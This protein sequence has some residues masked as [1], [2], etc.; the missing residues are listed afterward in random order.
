MTT[1][2]PYVGATWLPSTIVAGELSV[3]DASTTQTLQTVSTYYQITQWTTVQ[4]AYNAQPSVANSNIVIDV[5]GWY[6]C[7]VNISYNVGTTLQMIAAL[8]VNGVVHSNGKVKKTNGVVSPANDQI[9]ILD[10]NYFNVGDVV[11]VR[12]GTT[13]QSNPV[14]FGL[15]NGNFLLFLL[16]ERPHP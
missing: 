16:G 3:Q 15:T 12:V 11:D 14:T 9:T 4:S 6:W 13:N 10:L 5:A 8:F 1:S 7:A 2:D